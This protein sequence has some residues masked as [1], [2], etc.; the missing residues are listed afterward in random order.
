M[1]KKYEK[2]VQGKLGKQLKGKELEKRLKQVRKAISEGLVEIGNAAA[3]SDK[4][5]GS[6]RCWM[7]GNAFGVEYSIPDFGFGSF[8]FRVTEG[9]VTVKGC[10][11]SGRLHCVDS[12]M[13]SRKFVKDVLCRLVDEAKWD[14]DERPR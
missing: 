2:E 9:K 8:A 3:L 13:M 10:F 5:D 6:V 1:K 7:G 14:H 12:E 4:G 11:P